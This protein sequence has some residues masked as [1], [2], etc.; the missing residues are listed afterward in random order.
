M[1][2]NTWGVQ[3]GKHWLLG[4]NPNN[5]AIYRAIPVHVSF[6]AMPTAH[7]M[8]RAPVAAPAK[9]CSFSFSASICQRH[10]SASLSCQ[11][12]TL[13]AVL[14]QNRLDLLHDPDGSRMQGMHIQ[15]CWKVQVS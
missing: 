9:S 5:C 14:R 10:G 2:P 7:H 4:A 12:Y 11:R 3:I 1:S 8:L 13:K 15:D 6:R